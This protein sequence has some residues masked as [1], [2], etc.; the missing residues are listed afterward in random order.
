MASLPADFE[1]KRRIVQILT[2]RFFPNVLKDHPSFRA[3][4]KEKVSEETKEKVVHFYHREDISWTNPGK[5]D[6]IR[7]ISESG[8][9]SP[10]YKQKKFLM[11]TL[12]ETYALFKE[13][14]GCLLSFS[15]FASLR[16]EN[17]LRFGK[18]PHNVCLCRIHEN[19]IA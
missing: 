6:Y 7:S 5:M 11:T 1:R 4:R 13:E 12:K 18:T 19:F 16:P 2:N 15:L 3:F 8:R 9:G 10:L 17:V 14:H